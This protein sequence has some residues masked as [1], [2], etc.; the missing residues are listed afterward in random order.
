M[1]AHSGI[2]CEITLMLLVDSEMLRG[3]GKYVES[4]IGE[5]QSEFLFIVKEL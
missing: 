3:G 4:C 1:W 5:S 2:I